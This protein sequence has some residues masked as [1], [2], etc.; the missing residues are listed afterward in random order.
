M[1]FSIAGKYNKKDYYSPVLYKIL[2]RRLALT[3]NSVESAVI[4]NIFASIVR[5]VFGFNSLTDYRSRKYNTARSQMLRMITQM[6]GERL[7]EWT[8]PIVERTVFQE[9][10]ELLVSEDL[11]SEKEGNERDG[12]GR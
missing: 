6:A 5:N 8:I 1:F 3:L 2:A 12:E 4:I 7:E 11:I 10:F 9:E